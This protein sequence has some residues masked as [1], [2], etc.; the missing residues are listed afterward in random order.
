[1][2]S[3]PVAELRGASRSIVVRTDDHD[4]AATVLAE[5][6]DLDRIEVEGDGLVVHLGDDGRVTSP[7][8]VAALVA[9][10]IGVE[11]LTPRGRL[12]DVFLDLTGGTP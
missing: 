4:R 10:G 11:S 9:A 12:E 6:L 8:V 3:G 1:L 7:A 2:V 5:A